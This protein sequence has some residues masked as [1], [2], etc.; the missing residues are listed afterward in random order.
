M[1]PLN[2]FRMISAELGENAL[3]QFGLREQLGSPPIVGPISLASPT[4]FIQ[5]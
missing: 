2:H 5:S 1:L 4:S 3:N